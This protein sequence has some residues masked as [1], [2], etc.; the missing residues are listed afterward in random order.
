LSKWATL[1]IIVT[2]VDDSSL[3]TDELL[4]K[5]AL[6]FV[7]PII[8]AIVLKRLGMFEDVDKALDSMIG[9]TFSKPDSFGSIHDGLFRN[10]SLLRNRIDTLVDVNIGSFDKL[11][12][13]VGKSCSQILIGCPTFGFNIIL[14]ESEAFVMST[15]QQLIMYEPREYTGVLTN[16]DTVDRSFEFRDRDAHVLL[17]GRVIDPVFWKSEDTYKNALEQE[18]AI[19]VTVK[20]VAWNGKIIKSFI[21]GVI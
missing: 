1:E 6:D 5:F 14:D 15:S 13:P 8:R 10:R 19:S 2:R 17:A 12:Q 7:L 18:K 21:L 16:F 11:V 3:E 4:G 20:S 9:S